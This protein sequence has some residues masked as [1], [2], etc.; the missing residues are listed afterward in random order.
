MP[1]TPAQFA[2]GTS[3]AFDAKGRQLAW[4]PAHWAGA[5]V[6]DVPVSVED[7]PYVRFGD[8]ALWLAWTVTAGAAALGLI[9]RRR[10]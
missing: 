1:A 10:D 7:T 2:I 3:S 9:R 8:W 4:H 6:V 5:L